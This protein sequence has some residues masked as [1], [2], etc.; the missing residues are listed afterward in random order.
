MAEL[1]FDKYHE[2]DVK[3]FHYATNNGYNDNYSNTTLGA[4]LG[5]GQPMCPALDALPMPA[6]CEKVAPVANVDMYRGVGRLGEMVAVGGSFF[7]VSAWRSGSFRGGASFRQAVKLPEAASAGPST[8]EIV[9]EPDV[10]DEALV[11]EEEEEETMSENLSEFECGRETE[12]EPEPVPKPEPSKRSKKK[13]S[14][15][16]L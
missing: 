15:R 8:A 7:Q 6:A 16:R 3:N 4:A 14:K 12:A 11:G 10:V 2:Y 5:I 1:Y 9:A 13:G